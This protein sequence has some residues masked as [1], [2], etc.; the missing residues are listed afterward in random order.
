MG[1]YE[2]AGVS[3]PCGHYG[4]CTVLARVVGAAQEIQQTP[5]VMERVYRNMIRRYNVCNELSDRH[6]EPLL[7]RININYNCKYCAVEKV[8]L[9][10]VETVLLKVTKWHFFI[11]P[12]ILDI[13]TKSMHVLLR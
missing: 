11:F 3:D 12:L 7:K 8:W 2:V 1:P 6:I 4:R 5:G 9:I 10:Y 13:V